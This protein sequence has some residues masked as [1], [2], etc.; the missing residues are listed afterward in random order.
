MSADR[1]SVAAYRKV[2]V[3]SEDEEC[4]ALIQWAETQRFG[5]FKLSEVLILVPNGAFHGAD[6][7]A[8]AVV[9]RKLREKGLRPGVF[10]YVLP[11]P[12]YPPCA[13]GFVPGLWLEMKRTRGGE[14]SKEQLAFQFR[15]RTLGWECAIANGWEQARVYINQHLSLAGRKP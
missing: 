11:V 9:A 15:M 8:G 7:K 1:L 6:R 14:T 10:D 2:T 13:K 12:L 5:M 4:V 3:Q